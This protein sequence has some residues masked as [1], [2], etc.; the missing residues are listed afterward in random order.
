MTTTDLDPNTIHQLG[1]RE[2]RRIEKAQEQIAHR[3]GY[4]S[5]R[6]LRSNLHGNRNLVPRSREQLLGLYRNY[7][8]QM[9][10]VL[11]RMF[12]VGAL[13]PLE[14]RPV[15]TYSENAAA[16]AKYLQAPP[17]G[18]RAAI[19]LINTGRLQSRTLVG[20]ESTAYHESVPAIIYKSRSPYDLR[21]LNFAGKEALRP[22][23]R[24]GS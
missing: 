1:L 13:P 19:L 22:L 2:V 18:S 4:S 8:S 12:H 16:S 21:F 11:P 10:A 3:L 7:I 14:I 6:E 15:P 9:Q 20:V 17:D 23:P 24:D 5:V